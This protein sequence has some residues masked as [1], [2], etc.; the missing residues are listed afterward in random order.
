MLRFYSPIESLANH[1]HKGSRKIMKRYGLRM[2]PW[3]VMQVMGMG[4]ILVKWVLLPYVVEC[5]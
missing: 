1:V 5:S 3:I 4:G 2:P